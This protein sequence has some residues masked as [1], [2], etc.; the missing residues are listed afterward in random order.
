MTAPRDP[1]E[2]DPEAPSA[3]STPRQGGR[4]AAPD[5]EPEQSR[6]PAAEESAALDPAPVDAPESSDA[7]FGGAVDAD[8]PL[9]AKTDAT[10]EPATR[11]TSSAEGA[12]RLEASDARTA[13]GAPAS[14]PARRRHAAEGSSFRL[15]AWMIWLASTIIIALIAWL[16][17]SLATGDDDDQEQS[18][19]SS[20]SAA[21]STS[22]ASTPVDVNSLPQLLCMGNSYITIETGLSAEQ[23]LA[24]PGAVES[25]FP[26]S[27]LS[28]IPPGCIA[29]T[30]TRDDVVLAMG[31]YPSIEEACTAGAELQ[32]VQFTAY[33]GSASE[34]LEQ[35]S[36]SA[37]SSGGPA[38][39]GSSG[40]GSPSG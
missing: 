4:H 40:S 18:A 2:I 15:P 31:P 21:A 14:T 9:L 29:D 17:I 32:G 3:P 5:D 26:G 35:T 20:T 16:V 22:A 36:C 19:A 1:G 25:Q 34:G 30:D 33:A 11:P 13:S 37:S 23:M 10:I 28:T 7:G 12:E 24:D 38:G 27:Q 8:D 6:P 39:G